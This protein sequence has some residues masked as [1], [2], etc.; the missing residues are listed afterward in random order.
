MTPLLSIVTVS[1]NAA[2]TIVDTLASVAGQRGG[3]E[4]EHVCVD[5]GSRDDTRAL[6]DAMAAR[7]AHLR[8]VFEPDHGIYDAMNKGFAACRGE[9]VLY[10]NADD[11]LFAPDTLS[12]ALAGLTRGAPD[13]PDLIVGDVVMGEPGRCGWWR[14][15]RVPRLLA[16]WPGC[17]LFPIHQGRIVRRA[18]IECVG[19][20]DARSRLAADVIQFYDMERA[21]PLSIRVI[22]S[23]IAFMRGGGAA[24]GSPGAMWLGTREIFAHL[25]RTHGAARAGAMTMVKTLQSLSEVRFGRCPGSRWF[26]A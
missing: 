21:R 2:D 25:G 8:R 26:A 12:Q 14:D 6:I 7:H 10:L 11:F 17:G 5:G 9:Y 24:N 13:N 1:L 15:R 22:A 4:L 19:G 3:V 23:P 18:L 16:R 20:F